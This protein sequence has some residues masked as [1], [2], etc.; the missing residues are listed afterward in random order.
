MS[1]SPKKRLSGILKIALVTLLLV[2]A[3]IVATLYYAA[4]QAL[5]SF[6]PFVSQ[7]SAEVDTHHTVPHVTPT[8]IPAPVFLELQPFTATLH[9]AQGRRRVLYV[10]I[11]LRV[12]D[13]NARGLFMDY[14]PEVRD[15]VLRELAQQDP[16]VVQTPKGRT[17][18]A[19]A[20]INA[21]EASY[22][23]YLPA[24]RVHGV[25]FTAFVVQ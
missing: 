16:V 17:Q 24:P 4:P 11:T 25:L 5:Y 8:D 18:L 10:A 13:E 2:V 23:P 21:L 12:D 7:D 22:T 9:D 14:M 6:V 15:R 20:L 1:N 3:T 19:E